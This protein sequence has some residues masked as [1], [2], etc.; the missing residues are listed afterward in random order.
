MRNKC[1]NSSD[2][3]EN[4]SEVK[5][6]PEVKVNYDNEEITTESD[7]NQVLV[8]DAY[9]CDLSELETVHLTQATKLPAK[10]KKW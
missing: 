3:Q 8:E 1:N 10:H 2:K 5:P 7:S 6:R 9:D 4:G